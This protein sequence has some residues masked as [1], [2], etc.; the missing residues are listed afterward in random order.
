MLRIEVRAET[1]G[2]NLQ[3][4][5][6]LALRALEGHLQPGEGFAQD[7]EFGGVRAASG[8]R[9]NSREIRSARP[10]TDARRTRSASVRAASTYVGSFM[11]VSA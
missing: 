7:R 3:K 9:S 8:S 6:R 10:G 1:G 2:A 11:S 4:L 5:A